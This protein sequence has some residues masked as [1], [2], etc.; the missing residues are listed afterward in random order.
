MDYNH[1]I[2]IYITPIF[3]RY[4]YVKNDVIMSLILSI[5]KKNIE[6]SLFWGFELYHSGFKQ[7]LIELLLFI[8]IEF[9]KKINSV[10]I[11]H[12][13]Y[14]KILEWKSDYS[15]THLIATII[16]NIA[17][18]DS[19]IVDFLK[20]YGNK[21]LDKNTIELYDVYKQ[22][23]TQKKNIIYII[24]NE[25]DIKRFETVALDDKMKP[26]HILRNACKYYSIKNAYSLFDYIDC[27]P[28]MKFKPF[29]TRKQ[30]ANFYLYNWLFYSYQTPIWK[31]RIKTFKGALDFKESKVIFMNDDLED[32]FYEEYGYEPDEQPAEIFDNTIGYET[33]E[34]IAELSL[35]NFITYNFDV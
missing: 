20:K 7:E 14:K 35:E 13:I 3:T 27:P 18:R 31:N 2:R 12:F 34:G 11:K 5:L 24:Y 33:D 9:H 30:I 22:K 32:L 1:N 6:K 21:L 4:L 26:R 25:S 23:N 16:A 28:L 8:Y 10:K 29:L 19:D 17:C 15:K